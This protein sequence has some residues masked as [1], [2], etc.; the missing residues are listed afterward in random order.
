MDGIAALPLVA[1]DCLNCLRSVCLQIAVQVD[2]FT[3]AMAKS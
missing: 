1:S 2:E 3:F